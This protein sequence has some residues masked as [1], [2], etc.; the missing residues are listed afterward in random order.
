VRICGP[1]LLVAWLLVGMFMSGILDVPL[2]LATP[3]SQT[4]AV[5]TFGLATNNGEYAQAAAVYCLYF[6]FLAL[7]IGALALLF[8]TVRRLA[9]TARTTSPLRPEGGS[10]EAANMADTGDGAAVHADRVRL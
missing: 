1:S 5:L 2:L 8:L 3:G 7:V 10:D 6:L 9:T 4:V